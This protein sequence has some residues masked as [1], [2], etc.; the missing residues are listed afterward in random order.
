MTLSELTSLTPLDG[1]YRS[2]TA[3]LSEYF[4]EYALIK[5]RIEIETKYLVALSEAEVVRSF[6][7]NEKKEL[8]AIVENFSVDDADEVKKI[9]EETRHDVKA[10]ERWLRSKLSATSL[11]DCVEMI[12]FGLTSEDINNIANRLMLKRATEKVLIPSLDSI[13]SDIVRKADEESS[14]AMLA[15][16]H[17]QAAIPTTLGKE[18]AVF[19]VRLSDQVRK[20]GS[21]KLTGKLNGAVGNYNALVAAKP[22]VDWIEFSE[23]FIGS[24]GLEPNLFTTQI[25]PYDDIAEYFQ[26]YARINNILI[27]FNQ[28]IWRYISDGWFTQENKA[29]EVGSST[30]PQKIN[31]IDFENSE[32]NL[33]LSNSMFEFMIRKLTVSRLQRDLSDSTVMRNVGTALGYS[34]LSYKSTLNGLSRIKTNRDAITKD[35]NSDSSILTEGV[36][37]I[38][39]NAGVEDPYSLVK[40]LSRGKHITQEDWNNW[41]EG[42][43]IDQK[44]KDEI[45]KL[46]PENYVGLAKELTDQAIQKIKENK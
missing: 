40:D 44:Y 38:L 25:N 17:G 18:L 12:H 19:A 14:T 16:T 22:E 31:P 4:S 35:L 34:L 1:R 6:N 28:D 29:G 24:L 3:D 13:I 27:G 11:S 21:Q 26:N 23:K 45:S 10:A 8:L 46:S 42:L 30:M 20:L 15:R 9:E 5:T 7:D 43:S 32:G 2:K 41:V 37:T 39:R 36:Q 33:G